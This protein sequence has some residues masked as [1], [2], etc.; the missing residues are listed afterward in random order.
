MGPVAG[1]RRS[2][3]LLSDPADIEFVLHHTG[4]IFSRTH[5]FLGRPVTE[6]DVT[7]WDSGRKAVF[8]GLRTAVE[9]IAFSSIEQ[10]F[11][12]LVLDW[13]EGPVDDGIARFE[14]A[15][16]SI[17]GRI[18]FGVDGDR[19]ARLAGQL[20]DVLFEISRSPFDPPRWAPVRVRAQQCERRLREEVR[21]AVRTRMSEGSDAD[22]AGLL[23]HPDNDAI[24]VELATRMLI[25][26]MLA[27]HGVPAVALAWTIVLLDKYPHERKRIADEVGS[28]SID[29]L[30]VS[31][32]S[33]SAAIN[34]TLR[35]YPPTW[36]LARKL[37]RD[38]TIHGVRFQKG[39]TFYMSSF[40]TGRASEYF[41][42][43]RAFLPSRWYNPDFKKQ[44]PS[45]AYFP[46]GAGSRRCLGQFLA[47]FE[48]K[49]L[50]ALIVRECNLTVVDSDKVRLG[51]RRG[52]RPLNLTLLRAA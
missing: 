48:L 30:R 12:R 23:T 37:L 29:S 21:S 22:L 35:L 14:T 52:L 25:S 38:E 2:L 10:A 19:F 33:T 40:I 46:F 50:T 8:A 31:L 47:T 18:C 43:P 41:E 27:G 7:E 13:P 15:T 24:D 28:T 5:N 4:D 26:V 16:S 39:H 34:E 6:T 49:L 20:L 3:T 45:Y 17:I 42:Y 1:I 36:L 32:P 51:A 11:E 44:L 9:R